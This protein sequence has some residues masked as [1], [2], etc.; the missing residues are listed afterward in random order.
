MSVTSRRLPLEPEM[1]AHEGL[2][3]I[4]ADAA[5]RSAAADP[6]RNI[7]LEASAGTGKTRVLV[8]R[9]V[10]LLLAGVDPDNILAITFTRKAAAE[11][12]GRIVERLKEAGRLSQLDAGRWRDLRERLGD[13]A[14][15]TI[16]AFCL[17]LLREFPLEAD[18]DPGF[19]L[20]DETEVARLL[21][22]SIDR[23]LRI[24]RAH[25]RRDDDVAL[26]FAQLGERR[27][28]V[29]L[30]ALLD[31]RLVAPAVLRRFLERG[32]RDMSAG[33]ACQEARDRLAHV[34]LSV[35]GGL[36]LFLSDGPVGHP[37]FAML[38]ADIRELCGA[39]SFQ[40]VLQA[41]S[42]QALFRSFV[43]QLRAYFLTQQGEPRKGHF[44][45]T[46]FNA[47]DCRSPDSWRRHR[48]A[49]AAIAPQL[50][51]A[52]RGFRRDLNVAMSRGVWRIFAV[53]LATYQE[54]LDSH[55][56]LDFPGVLERALELL[57]QMDEFARSRYRLEARYH[58]WTS[59]KT[60]V[61]RNGTW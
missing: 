10:N 25:A 46:G 42:D 41:R 12:R 24:C 38:A 51:E 39:R 29:G 18:V 13:I 3:E 26:V 4:Q 23:A 58:R 47:V 2:Q 8:E 52:V 17:S 45:G 53:A 6:T 57:G 56:L 61:A 27:L 34:L 37:A 30:S 20:A 5:A 35:T 15:S 32:P 49:A 40:S 54:T 7:V 59:S 44:A 19:A 33:R 1:P 22:E 28:R 48:G 16:D 60:R 50:A 36:D 11:M 43:D 21:D 31:R 55:A 14:I 9:Y